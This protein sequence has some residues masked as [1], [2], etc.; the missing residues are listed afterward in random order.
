MSRATRGVVDGPSR[1]RRGDRHGRG[2]RSPVT[3]P[4]LP[5]VH[6]RITIF[7][8]TV[9]ATAEY[10]RNMWPDEL[11]G[12]SFEIAATPNGLVNDDNV[13]RWRVIA[14]ERRII[15]Y[16]LPIQRL[17]HL[18]CN[19]EIHHRVMVEMCVFRA[20]A[21]LIGKDPWDFPPNHFHHM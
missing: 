4:H 12:V 11:R 8:K 2:L 13:E 21:E 3:G 19:D 14:D 1:I 20:V 9:T 7:E 6:S 17:G 5:P 16:R 15:L 18:H 10:V